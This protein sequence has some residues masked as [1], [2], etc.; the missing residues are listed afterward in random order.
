MPI[1]EKLGAGQPRCSA[2]WS[3]RFGFHRQ[4]EGKSLS[5]ETALVNLKF[6]QQ[7]TYCTL[8]HHRARGVKF[9]EDYQG[10]GTLLKENSLHRCYCCWV[11]GEADTRSAARVHVV[12]LWAVSAGIHPVVRVRLLWTCFYTDLLPL[13]IYTTS[14]RMLKAHKRIDKQ[15]FVLTC[16]SHFLPCFLFFLK[17]FILMWCFLQ[18]EAPP[19]ENLSLHKQAACE[20]FFCS[21]AVLLSFCDH[22]L[23][24]LRLFSFHSLGRWR[25]QRDQHHPCGQGGLR[26]SWCLSVWTAQSPGTGILWQ[27]NLLLLFRFLSI[28]TTCLFFSSSFAT[29]TPQPTKIVASLTVF[30]VFVIFLGGIFWKKI[31]L[32]VFLVRKVT[33]P[34]ANQLYAMKVLKKATLKGTATS[35][36]AMVVKF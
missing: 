29:L 22:W 2:F 14:S 8:L 12:E 35:A 36:L 5:P 7:G 20:I 26:E 9:K 31:I 13:N 34:D 33:P 4:K 23:L 32:Q 1:K 18:Q 6:S 21:C 16:T 15:L 3:L 25:H 28:L 24:S 30:L 11:L 10:R 27:G 17:C 19:Q